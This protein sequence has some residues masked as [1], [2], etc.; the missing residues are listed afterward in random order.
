MKGKE[1]QKYGLLLLFIAF[2]SAVYSFLYQTILGDYFYAL[3]LIHVAG[4]AGL[5]GYG[6]LLFIHTKDTSNG[7]TQTPRNED[8]F[9][10]KIKLVISSGIILGVYGVWWFIVIIYFYKRFFY[11]PLFW[12]I[13]FLCTVCCIGIGV[14]S[15]VLI[16]HLKKIIAFLTSSQKDPLFSLCRFILVKRLPGILILCLGILCIIYQ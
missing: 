15:I 5:I 13:T 1:A 9:L 10:A 7:T 16:A 8:T 3:E 11:W 14:F 2:I 6:L 4:P 12:S